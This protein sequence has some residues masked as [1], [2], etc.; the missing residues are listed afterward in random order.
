[1]VTSRSQPGPFSQGIAARTPG[2]VPECQSTSNGEATSSILRSAEL[3]AE[4]FET[5]VHNEAELNWSTLVN[6]H[7]LG[8]VVARNGRRLVRLAPMSLGTVEPRLH[9]KPC[10]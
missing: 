10:W 1:M 9:S 5:S 7:S 3:H 4:A 8:W 6:E 2:T